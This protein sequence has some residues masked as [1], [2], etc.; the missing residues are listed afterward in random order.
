MPGDRAVMDAEQIEACATRFTEML[1]IRR[2]AASSKGEWIL[3]C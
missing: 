3:R 2:F 1:L